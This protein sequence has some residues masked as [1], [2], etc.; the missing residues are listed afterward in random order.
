M[1]DSGRFSLPTNCS[2]E[3]SDKEFMDCGV[4]SPNLCVLEFSEMKIPKLYKSLFTC[5]DELVIEG[6][7]RLMEKLPFI[8]S[9]L[10]ESVQKV[11]VTDDCS[12]QNKKILVLGTGQSALVRKRTQRLT[13]K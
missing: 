6:V 1:A 13:V 4:R 8:V 10:Q 9:E 5:P 7:N 12:I 3:F 2:S 11:C